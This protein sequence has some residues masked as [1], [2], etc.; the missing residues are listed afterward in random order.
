MQSYRIALRDGLGGL[1]GDELIR[2]R[3][4]H[5]IN[6]HIGSSF[7]VSIFISARLRT[8]N[9]AVC[10]GPHFYRFSDPWNVSTTSLERANLPAFKTSDWPAR[11]PIRRRVH[12]CNI[13]PS[14]NVALLQPAGSCFRPAARLTLHDTRRVPCHAQRITPRPTRSAPISDH[15]VAPRVYTIAPNK[16]VARFTGKT[17]K[18]PQGS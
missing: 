10:L 3:V 16:L 18:C 2:Q 8:F 5:W 4:E 12:G 7:I 9:R 13:R 14:D 17:R 15:Q 1:A 6:D 11:Y